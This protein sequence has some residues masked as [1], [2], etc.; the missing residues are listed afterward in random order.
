[1][2]RVVTIRARRCGKTFEHEIR[3]KVQDGIA[4]F[5]PPEPDA[6]R[7]SV[8]MSPARR[9]VPTVPLADRFLKF[10]GGQ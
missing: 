1:M 2:N 8:E 4:S 6:G 10:G 7:S 3:V 9:P 5:L